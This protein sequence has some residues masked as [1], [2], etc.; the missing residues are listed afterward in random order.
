MNKVAL[1]YFLGLSKDEG[2]N[3]SV[4]PPPFNEDIAKEIPLSQISRDGQNL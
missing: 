3:N 2:K 1:E 4:P